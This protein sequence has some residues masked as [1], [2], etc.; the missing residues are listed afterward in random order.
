MI[1]AAIGDMEVVMGVLLLWCA[2]SVLVALVLARL[3][4]LAD[5]PSTVRQ[6]LT[7]A[8]LPPDFRPV[9]DPAPR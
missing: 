3:I 1:I 6:P 2:S 8:D 4:R 7:T 9:P 5:A